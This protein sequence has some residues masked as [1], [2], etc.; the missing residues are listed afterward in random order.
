M[1]SS[2]PRPNVDAV[3]SAYVREMLDLNPVSQSAQIIR[4]R[5]ELWRPDEVPRDSVGQSDPRAEAKL[6]QRAMQCLEALQEKFYELPEDKV[7]QYIGF[8]EQERLPEFAVRA[9]R[10][11]EVA[12]HRNLL[13]R[14]N[15]ETQDRKFSYSLLHGLVKP[16]AEAGTLHEQYIESIRNE[17]RI[18]HAVRMIDELLTSYPSV[19]ELERDWFDA[20]R[21]VRKRS[22]GLFGRESGVGPVGI[23]VIAAIILTAVI[24]AVSDNSSGRKRSYNPP[25]Q[26]RFKLHN[27]IPTANQSKPDAATVARDSAMN[28]YP[29]NRNPFMD[30]LQ[31][32]VEDVLADNRRRI[33]AIIQQAQE[34][35]ERTTMEMEKLFRDLQQPT[36]D[37]LLDPKPLGSY[38]DEPFPPPRKPRSEDIFQPPNIPRPSHPSFNT[39]PQDFRPPSFRDRSSPPTTTRPGYPSTTFPRSNFPSRSN[40]PNTRSGGLSN[41]TYPRSGVPR[42]SFPTPSFPR[43]NFQPPSTPN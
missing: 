3:A 33:D 16:A 24:G 28:P 26:T 30:P 1:S 41:P 23:G 34:R 35:G 37:P 42:P 27:R 43:P 12:K 6:R 15:N 31:T 39:L 20:I 32:D 18:G 21:D 40:Q 2:V 8:L 10:F 19:Y 38:L 13:I 4:R 22:G 14:I 11:R 25:A 17:G 36:L 29:T 9:A 7:E 5:R